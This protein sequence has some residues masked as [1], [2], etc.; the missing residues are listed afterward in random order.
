MDDQ[1]FEAGARY[2]GAPV[3]A[4][5]S[6]GRAGGE[7]ENEGN[8]VPGNRAQQTGEQYLLIDEF[9]VNHAFANGAGDGSA[10]HEGGDEIPEGRP[11][12][13]AKGREHARG[14]H[15]GDGIGGVVPAVREFEGQGKE[16]DHE[17]KGE[18][19]HRLRPLPR[20]ES[21]RD[22]STAQPRHFAGA[23]WEEKTGLLRSG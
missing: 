3:A 20:P 21:K 11:G 13:S 9:D 1:R 19:S 17:E 7:A 23:K 16:D 5:K 18:A 22:P 4:N 2:G 14:D 6:V 8:E 15:G 12:D 10:E